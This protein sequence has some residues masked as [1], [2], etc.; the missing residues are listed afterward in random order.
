MFRYIL[1]FHFAVVFSP[2]YDLKLVELQLSSSSLGVSFNEDFQRAYQH[3]ELI[4]AHCIVIKVIV[5]II[6]IPTIRGRQFLRILMKELINNSVG[7]SPALAG[8]LLIPLIPRLKKKE[9]AN[10][11][12][13]PRKG[14]RGLILVGPLSAEVLLFTPHAA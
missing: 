9:S 12:W 1:L 7:G 13:L 2:F 6:D 3:V 11:R 14:P 10:S 8:S 5:E 4:R